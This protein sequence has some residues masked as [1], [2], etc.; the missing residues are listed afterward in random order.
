MFIL[1]LGK[2]VLIFFCMNFK[3]EEFHREKLR[4]YQLTRLKYYYAVVTCDSVETA[5]NIYEQ[6]DGIEYESS[7]TKLDLR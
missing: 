4:Q 5:N 7:S 2:Q 3:G 6:C 1:K